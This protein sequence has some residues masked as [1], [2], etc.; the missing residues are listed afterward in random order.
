MELHYFLYAS[1]PLSLSFSPICT[2]LV[3]ATRMTIDT[4][5]TLTFILSRIDF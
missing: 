5:V 1:W 3:I 2:G 4:G